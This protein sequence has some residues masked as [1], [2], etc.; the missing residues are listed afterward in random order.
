MNR[1]EAVK[2]GRQNNNKFSLWIVVILIFLIG[3]FW[4][5]GGEFGPIRSILPIIRRVLT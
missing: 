4:G 1:R 5:G 2:I 3:A